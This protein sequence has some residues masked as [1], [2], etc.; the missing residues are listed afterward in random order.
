MEAFMQNLEANR[1]PLHFEE[2]TPRW[3]EWLYN[4]RMQSEHQWAVAT[5]HYHFLHDVVAAKRTKGERTPNG[6]KQAR[7][8]AMT[9]EALYNLGQEFQKEDSKEPFNH[10]KKSRCVLLYE[11]SSSFIKE[12]RR[13]VGHLSDIVAIGTYKS[14]NMTIGDPNW[15]IHSIARQVKDRNM[16]ATQISVSPQLTV[17]REGGT[18]QGHVYGVRWARANATESALYDAPLR[19]GQRRTAEGATTG[20]WLII[21]THTYFAVSVMKE[22]I[23]RW[24]FSFSK[25]FWSMHGQRGVCGPAR[26]RPTA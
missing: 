26:D 2:Q 18:S 21:T 17:H 14:D 11:S 4:D 22:E 12:V 20:K 6:G 3:L 19:Y 24:G 9:R 8:K 23:G 7:V 13:E 25:E 15:H 5:N 1:E 16:D 10:S